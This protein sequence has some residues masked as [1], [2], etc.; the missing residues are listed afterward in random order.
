[1]KRSGK[2]LNKYRQTHPSLGRSPA[3]ELFGYFE[4]AKPGSALLRIISSGEVHDNGELGEWEH[5]SVSLPNRCPTWDEMCF[6]KDLFWDKDET[7]IQFHPRDAEYVSYHD[8][9]LH[10]WKRGE[11]ELPPTLAVGPLTQRKR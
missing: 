3:D 2:H 1:M 4:A 9:C 5:V 6:V 10:L 8:Y 11:H 7:V